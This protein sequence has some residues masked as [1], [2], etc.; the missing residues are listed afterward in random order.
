[1]TATKN[2]KKNSKKIK[3]QTRNPLNADWIKIAAANVCEFSSF[4]V[5][6][7]VE[8]QLCSSAN[9]DEDTSVEGFVTV[10]ASELLMEFR[11]SSARSELNSSPQR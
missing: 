5:L 1:M 8:L 6:I 9:V 2:L 11:S 7:I 4:S 10:A 3:L